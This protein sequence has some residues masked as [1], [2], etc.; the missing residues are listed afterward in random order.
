M[1]RKQYYTSGQ[2]A[3]KANVSVRTIR[4]YDQQELLKPSFLNE[5]GY[6]MYTDDDFVRL[7][8]ILTF[9]Y[10]GFSLEEIRDLTLGDDSLQNIQQS[11]Q[12]QLGMVRQRIAHWQL[13]EHS[14]EDTARQLSRNQE[15]DWSELL[16]LIHL[17]S[18]ERGLVEQYKNSTN[19]N[20]RVQ[21]HQ[22][23]ATNPEGWFPWIFRHLD[24]QSGEQVLELGCGNGELW[25][26]RQNLIPQG[27]QILLSDVS[28]GMVADVENR[29]ETGFLYQ[30]MDCQ[31]IP[32][33][34]AS[35]DKVIA[36]HVLFYLQDREQALQEIRRVLKPGGIFLCSTYGHQH[37]KEISQLVQGFDSRIR[38]AQVSLSDIFG[39]E[40]GEAELSRYFSQTERIDYVDSLEVDRAEP[41]LD[42]ILSCHG[43]QH[44]YLNE[45]YTA[46]RSYVKTKVEREG[47]FHITKEAGIFRCIK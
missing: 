29:L 9:R 44:E 13:V 27:C 28:P 46:F 35:F 16:R 3:K 12:L 42:Y 5:N 37:M 14:I 32:Y 33:P 26:G 30:V 25:A 41:L 45:N 6:R 24:L 20:I 15:V 17:T 22:K 38:L 18:Q 2:F 7:Q 43:N 39:L 23:Y 31:Q 19:I 4:Y 40:Q 34:E 21:L 47:T 36:N 8:K 11:L 1:E 10:L